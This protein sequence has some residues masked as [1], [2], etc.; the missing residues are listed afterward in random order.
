MIKRTIIDIN[1]MDLFIPPE[2]DVMIEV[3]R[4]PKQKKG[5]IIVFEGVDGSGKTFM[6][7]NLIKVYPDQFVKFPFPTFS[8]KQKLKDRL[9]RLRVN[10]VESLL[11]Y[12][13][14]FLQDILDHQFLLEKK[15]EQLDGKH[16]LLDRYYFSTICYLKN[17][18][19]KLFPSDAD[20]AV[21][22]HA[23]KETLLYK[24]LDKCIT[25]DH[26]ILLTN[27]FT[28]KGTDLM[29]KSHADLTEINTQ[30]H[31]E[32]IFYHEHLNMTQRKSFS[33][34]EVEAFSTTFDMIEEYLNGHS[35]INIQSR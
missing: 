6:I 35:I 29:P 23:L 3:D 17:D 2:L 15:L 32:I 1:E 13:F 5:K 34:I 33:W 31:N 24:S 30:Y 22:W 25:P 12:H 16:I 4:K 20:F 19:W 8:G 21:K 14:L 27:N 18:L 10:D 9:Q 11:D 28:E 7:D 26:V